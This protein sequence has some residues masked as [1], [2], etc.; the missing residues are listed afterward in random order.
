MSGMEADM[1]GRA[2]ESRG[3]GGARRRD[4]KRPSKET[5]TLV[6]EWPLGCPPSESTLWVFGELPPRAL[7]TRISVEFRHGEPGGRP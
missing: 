3:E 7:V 5:G 1:A 4:P 6:C 2:A